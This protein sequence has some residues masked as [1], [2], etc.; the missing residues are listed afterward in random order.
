MVHII[1]LWVLVHALV[2]HFF[3]PI[4]MSLFLLIT[5]NLGFKDFQDYLSV[6][7]WT[8]LLTHS[9]LLL[10]LLFFVTF[11]F[12]FCLYQQDKSSE[13]KAKFIQASNYCKK[14]LEGAKLAYATNTKESSLPRNLA[15]GTF[16]K[17]LIVFST[18]VNLLYLGK[19]VRWKLS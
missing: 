8:N 7:L 10:L 9:F 11:I 19:M 3:L 6:L 16:D 5:T 15:L 12:L 17:L 4:R 18:E 2:H 14:V 1:N 13:S